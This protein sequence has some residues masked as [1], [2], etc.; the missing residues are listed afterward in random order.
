MAYVTARRA[1]LTSVVLLWIVLFAE[2]ELIGIASIRGAWER[3]VETLPWQAERAVSML[4]GGGFPVWQKRYKSPPARVD[5][6]PVE[7]A[8]R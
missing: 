2:F 4:V 5:L 6:E 7:P 3:L 1:G 8:R